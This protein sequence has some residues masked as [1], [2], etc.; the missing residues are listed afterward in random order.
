MDD[1][2]SAATSKSY[3][4]ENSRFPPSLPIAESLSNEHECSYIDGQIANL[5]LKLPARL[6]TEDEFDYA[7]AGGLRRSGIFLYHTD[8]RRCSACEPTRVDV[9]QF[10][11]RDSF[12]RVLNR[13]D[14]ELTISIQRPVLDDCRLQLFNLHRSQRGL[15]DPDGK[16]QPEDYQSFLVETCLTQSLEL[17]FWMGS[18]LVGVSIVDCGRTSLSAVYT[19]FDTK[20]SKLSLGTYSVLKQIE[21]ARDSG[22]KFAYLGLYVASNKHLNY[23]ARFTP[24][25]RW[26]EGSW[27]RFDS[28]AVDG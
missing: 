6:L 8:C 5:P 19:Y 21:F 1:P 4:C 2:Q 16:Y 10:V 9:A 18:A 12:R 24:Q 27:V 13:G 22:R 23:K 25:E 20:H 15:G 28:P 14:R 11:W 3:S 7:M 17:S 26:I